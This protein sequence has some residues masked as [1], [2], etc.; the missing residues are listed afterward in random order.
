MSSVDLNKYKTLVQNSFLEACEQNNLTRVRLCIARNVDVNCKTDDG[1]WWG[2]RYA[3]EKNLTDLC[4]LLVSQPNIDV[5]M[6]DKNNMN[7]L[8]MAC[9]NGHDEIVKILTRQPQ[10]ELNCKDFY[11]GWSAIF[12]SLR[13]DYTECIRELMSVPGV[14][15]N[16]RDN[17]GDTLIMKTVSEGNTEMLEILREVPSIDW[18]MKD[19]YGDTVLTR[20]IKNNKEDAVNVLRTIPNLE[21]RIDDL[22][23]SSLATRLFSAFNLKLKTTAQNHLPECPVRVMFSKKGNVTNYFYFRFVMK[24]SPQH[25]MCSSVLRDTSHVED[26]NRCS[27]M[28]SVPNVVFPSLV[29]H[30]TLKTIFPHSWKHENQENLACI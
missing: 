3:S 22:R 24:H 29:E 1:L 18:N 12:W 6:K 2:L 28:M 7:C 17:V 30:L 27:R 5:S 26:V 21:I 20:A 4:S 15:W 10:I 13:L 23:D 19:T 11:N 9:F 25:L 16:A 14:D 8:M